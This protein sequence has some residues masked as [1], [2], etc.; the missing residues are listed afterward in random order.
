[1][2]L[3]AIMLTVQQPT[4]REYEVARACAAMHSVELRRMHAQICDRVNEKI[5]AW[6]QR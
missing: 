2:I 4:V 6:K 1:M 3:L 5:R